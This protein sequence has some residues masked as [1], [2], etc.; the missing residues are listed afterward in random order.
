MAE[1]ETEHWRSLQKNNGAA[2]EQLYEPLAGS[3]TTTIA[4]ERGMGWLRL[5]V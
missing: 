4:P 1:G 2:G 3:D 5:D